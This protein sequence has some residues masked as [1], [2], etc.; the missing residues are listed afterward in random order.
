VL[1][2]TARSHAVRRERFE[3][4]RLTIDHEF[5]HNP[6]SAWAMYVG[7]TGARLPRGTEAAPAA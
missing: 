3:A 5:A 6:S 2:G 7:G 4:L 1:P